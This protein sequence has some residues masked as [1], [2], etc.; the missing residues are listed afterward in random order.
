MDKF[1]TQLSQTGAILRAA[2]KKE[3]R[4][5]KLPEPLRAQPGLEAFSSVFRQ[6]LHGRGVVRQSQLD[7]WL[8]T[9]LEG[10][11]DPF[12]L[13]DMAVAC[14][15]IAQSIAA[16]ERIA[17]YGDYDADGVTACVTL[18][19]GLRSVGADVITYIPNRFTEGYGLNLEALNDLHA[20]GARLVITCDCGT[21][22]VEAAAGRPRGM[23][24]IVTDHH[25]VAAQRPAV[26]ALINPK[27]PDCAY[28]F[29][30][31]AACGVAYKLLVALERRVFRGKLDPGASLDAV[32]LGTV[33]D[34]VPLRAENRAIVRAGLRRL[35]EAPSP[36]CAAL[37]AVAGITAPVT[38]EHLAFQLGPRINAAGRMEDAMLALQLLMAESREEADPFAQRL[39]EQNA[40]RQQ[41]TAEIVRE[42]R[43]QVAEL[44]NG[45]AVIIMGADHW[46]L[47]VLGLAASRLVEEF[48][49]PTFIFNTEGD[50][51][52]GSA[53]SIESFHLVDCLQECAP[54]LHRFGGHAMAAGLTVLKSR[55]A[56]LE[57]CLEQYTTARLNGDAFS[58]PITIEATAV[59][60]DLKPSL[61]HELQML[62][63]FGVGNREPLLLSREVEVVRTETFGS[64]RRHLRVQVRDR[65]ASAE[66]IAFDKAAA[67]P[68][69]P[70][71]RRIDVVYALQCERWDGLDR[72]RLHLRDLRPAV[73]PALVLAGV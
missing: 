38:A 26:D 24:L 42:A 40:Q 29:D 9:D 41:L 71:G 5:W 13:K 37:L 59:F 15:L 17:I 47:G 67:A 68:H 51:W 18:A 58:R 55:F 31:L 6:I 12:L 14:D 69:L 64:D 62:A 23:R 3:R 27:Q 43:T 8:Q 72:I 28:P 48:Y 44:D 61:H 25:E 53:R 54:L 63:P 70:T 57:E 56:E 19:R 21:N 73:Q 34:V 11:P 30:G 60:A 1:D 66:A 65:T 39:H 20:R 45:A 10:A 16:G 52:R 7:P 22:S 50:E 49:R 33:A 4:N 46:P 36:G 32:A 2:L 35:S